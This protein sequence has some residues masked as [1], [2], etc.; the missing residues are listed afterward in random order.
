MGAESFFVQVLPAGVEAV[1][2]GGPATIRGASGLSRDDLL[3]R[4]GAQELSEDVYACEGIV[5]VT[6][7]EEELAEQGRAGVMSVA[8]EGCFACFAEALDAMF[9]VASRVPGPARF[10]HPL[11]VNM[12]LGDKQEFTT[13]MTSL[14]EVKRRRF[15]EVF[16]RQHFL[17]LPDS[18]FYR[19]YK[20]RLGEKGSV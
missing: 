6:F 10:F 16:G 20:K 14:Y 3:P 13:K 12:E 17:T 15:E 5:R 9:L 1:A 19:E 8:L 7:R 11:G 4:L 2:E 18:E